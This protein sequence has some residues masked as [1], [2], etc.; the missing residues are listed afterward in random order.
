M[1]RVHLGNALRQINLLFGKGTL[2]G[3]SDAQLLERHVSHGDELE[4]EALVQRHG[5]MV[6]AVCRGVLNDS[7]DA[8]DA[9]QAVF[10]MLAR[11]ARSLW[12]NDSLGGWLHRVSYRI[13]CQAKL[14]TARRRRQ[15]RRAAELAG[16]SSTPGAPWDD[17]HLVLHEEIDRLPDRYREPIVLCYLEHMTYEQAARHLCWS[18]ATTHGRL[19]RARTLLRRRLTRRGITV[20]GAALVALG[21]PNGAS[22]VSL[23]LFQS[24]LRS[25]RQFHLG[26]AA[27][28]GAVSTAANALVTQAT[29]SMMIAKFTK[30][31][32][33]VFFLGTLTAVASALPAG[34]NSIPDKSTS[35]SSLA[36]EPPQPVASDL[37]A[38][39]ER[40]SR[41]HRRRRSRPPS[42]AMADK[43]EEQA[44][45]LTKDLKPGGR[46]GRGDS[47]FSALGGFRLFM[48][49]DG[50]LVL[51]TIVE[52][53]LPDGVRV[54]LAH[55][56]DVLKFYTT[57]IWSLGTN[58]ASEQA[59]R[60]SYCI[61]HDDGNFVVYDGNGRIR[62]ESGTHGHPGSY[63]RCQDDG[64]VVIYTPDSQAIWSSGTHSRPPESLDHAA[65]PPLPVHWNVP[66]R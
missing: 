35:G 48:Q 30:I 3:L 62:F 16:A 39:G 55:T 20:A 6:L 2:A 41:R 33:A 9:F 5:P 64:N 65:L 34:G 23:V 11:K 47:L 52:D 36:S 13:A 45:N 1:T 18:E 31:A 15:E 8:D 26:K 46:L 57:K 29:R 12:I 4:F 63:L 44:L 40:Q 25:V 24:A 7:N 61:M 37:P 60:G 38:R 28:T 21:G 58:F 27:E 59:G 42:L 51:Y 50:D 49:A 66:R 10:L 19:A 54:V 56:P 53:K 22:A 17:T 43:K 14:D 32:A